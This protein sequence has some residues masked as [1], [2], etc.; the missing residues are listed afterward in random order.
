[1]EGEGR[2]DLTYHLGEGVGD[3][4][5]SGGAGAGIRAFFLL[6]PPCPHG[7][8][9]AQRERGGDRELRAP[10]ALRVGGCL[11]CLGGEN[12]LQGSPGSWIPDTRPLHRPSEGWVPILRPVCLSC[13]L[14]HH[15]Q[16]G[17]LQ[18][19]AWW[20][21]GS[22]PC[23]CSRLCPGGPSGDPKILPFQASPECLLP[24]RSLSSLPPSKSP[25][26]I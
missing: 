10:S 24:D 8:G 15:S 14:G 17:L 18:A 26:G 11:S 13:G 23:L 20:S 25:L 5:G 1:M 12:S 6:T 16:H 19:P 21:V 7:A 9:E 22:T 3:G 2:W 4:Q